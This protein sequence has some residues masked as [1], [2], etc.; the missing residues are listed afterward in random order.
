MTETLD[1]QILKV[2]A[3][4]STH[5]WA[6]LCHDREEFT[7]SSESFSVLFDRL[8]ARSLDEQPEA[9]LSGQAAL[10]VR[11][12]FPT[13]KQLVQLLVARQYQILADHFAPEFDLRFYSLEGDGASRF[14][15]LLFVE[16]RYKI[17]L[18]AERATQTHQSAR[19]IETLSPRESEVMTMVVA[20]MTNQSTAGALGLSPKTIEKHRKKM[21]TKLRVHSVAEVARIAFDAELSKQLLTGGNDVRSSVAH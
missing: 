5:Q 13:V 6:Y 2:V 12:S 18:S 4:E 7:F 9:S 16:S 1:Q 3:R 21:M 14:G 11:P 19:L 20:G 15:T 17:Y 8:S 10:M